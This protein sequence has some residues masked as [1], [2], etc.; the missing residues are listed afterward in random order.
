M[1]THYLQSMYS[2]ICQTSKQRSQARE[3]WKWY[4]SCF[5][6]I[7]PAPDPN[8]TTTK[9]AWHMTHMT[10]KHIWNRGVSPRLSDCLQT[11]LTKNHLGN[12]YLF[13][14]SVNLHSI[15]GTDT[16]WPPVTCVWVG[17]GEVP[18]TCIDCT[19]PV[20]WFL[21]TKK[22]AGFTCNAFGTKIPWI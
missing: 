1:Y 8:I 19:A 2:D 15:T 10:N 11:F 13:W 3:H 20:P 6:P 16:R 5:I 9:K 14:S 18:I 21:S 17:T 7:S 4:W 12:R 22:M